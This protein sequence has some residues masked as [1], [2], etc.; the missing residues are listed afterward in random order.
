MEPNIDQS[1]ASLSAI[2][3]ASETVCVAVDEAGRVLSS[4]EPTN[5]ASWVTG[6]VDRAGRTSKPIPIYGLAC[7]SE[8]LCIAGDGA[9]RILTSTD[10]TGGEPAWHVTSVEANVTIW[11]VSCASTS[12]CVAVDGGGN[13]LSSTD[14]EDEAWAASY[15]ADTHALEAV[16]CAAPSTCVAVDEAGNVV[17]SSDAAGGASAWTVTNVDGSSRQLT[18][19]SCASTQSCV[20]VDNRGEALVAKPAPSQTLTATI[21]GSGAGAI[22]GG[23]LSCPGSCSTSEPNGSVI[24]LTATPSSGSSFVGWSGACAGTGS[25]SLAMNSAETVTAEFAAKAPPTPPPGNGSSGPAPTKT[26]AATPAPTS[27]PAA[28]ATVTDAPTVAG[29]VISLQSGVAMP[30][31]CWAKSGSCLPVALTIT[32]VESIRAHRVVGV[33]P[34]AG[35]SVGVTRKTVVLGQVTATLTGGQTLTVRVV[36][37]RVGRELVRDRSRFLAELTIV[38]RGGKTLWKQ[39]VGLFARPAKHHR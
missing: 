25:C 22:T 28:P 15:R 14:P 35:H 37:N 12:L 8:S 3:C 11:G 23:G 21:S 24:A 6:A 16:S 1:G 32:A 31:H 18:A 19:V 26:S 29:G 36:L 27:T 34:S 20:A 13:V 7:P 38:P 33:G 9:G 17:T 4:Q 5:P 39:T 2:S 30:L 10:P